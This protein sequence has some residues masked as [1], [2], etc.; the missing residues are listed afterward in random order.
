M[1]WDKFLDDNGFTE[2]GWEVAYD[3]AIFYCPEDGNGIEPDGVC[4]CGERSPLL[5]MGMI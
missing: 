4:Y 2:K 1:D 5:Q 3:G